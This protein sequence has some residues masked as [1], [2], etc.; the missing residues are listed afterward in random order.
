MSKSIYSCYLEFD[1]FVSIEHEFKHK[2]AT[3][4][5]FACMDNVCVC[6]CNIEG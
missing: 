6:V 4:S 2:K 5:S 3:D 1:R